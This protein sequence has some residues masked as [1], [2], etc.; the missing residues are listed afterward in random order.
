MQII[1]MKI[2]HYA[3]DIMA[4]KCQVYLIQ[5]LLN[6]LFVIINRGGLLTGREETAGDQDTGQKKNSGSWKEL[7]PGYEGNHNR[8]T[9][10][11]ASRRSNSL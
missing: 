6:L 11:S 2:V 7:K 9:D 8:G 5:N 4:F 10:S 3:S 1:L